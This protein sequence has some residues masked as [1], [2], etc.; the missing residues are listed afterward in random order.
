MVVTGSRAHSRN[1][2]VAIEW[3]PYMEKS[4][5]LIERCESKIRQHQNSSFNP[6]N[7]WL[8]EALNIKLNLF[9]LQATTTHKYKIIHIV[10]NAG[11]NVATMD[12]HL[13]IV[14]SCYCYVPLYLQY[15][16]LLDSN[17]S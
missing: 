10:K 3:F 2:C 15:R 12:A 7:L 11:A 14:P 16:S 8:P 9:F 6:F 5:S 4:I 13:P 17:Y 1:A